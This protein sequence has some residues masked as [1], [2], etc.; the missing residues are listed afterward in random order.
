MDTDAAEVR[1]CAYAW[2]VAHGNSGTEVFY[3]DESG[4]VWEFRNEAG[5]YDGVGTFGRTRVQPPFDAAFPRDALGDWAFLPTDVPEHVGR[6]GNT[7][8]RLP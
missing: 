8:R 4:E 2:P 6:D 5:V 3:T 1:W 7:W